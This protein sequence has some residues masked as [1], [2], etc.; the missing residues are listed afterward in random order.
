MTTAAAAMR[1]DQ[2][3]T[4]RRLLQRQRLLIAQQLG[5]TPPEANSGY[6]RSMTMRFLI[7][8]SDLVVRV[9]VEFAT[10]LIGARFM[11]SISA[12]VSLSRITRT[13]SKS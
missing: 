5:P 7:R 12:A 13:G 8:R 9:L 2:C 4:L 6:P 11:K 10:L 1:L 3:E